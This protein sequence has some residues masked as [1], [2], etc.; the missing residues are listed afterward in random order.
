MIRLYEHEP[1]SDVPSFRLVGKPVKA[2][3][4]RMPFGITFSPGDKRLAVGYYDTAAVD[5]LDGTTLNR[6]SRQSPRDVKV[7]DVGTVSVEWSRDGQTLFAAGNVYDAK[8]RNLL[9]AWDRAGLG[10]ESRMTYCSPGTDTG[11]DALLGGR[12]LV[13]TR[14][15]V[16]ASWTHVANRSGPSRRRYS[17]R[18][19][20]PTSCACLRTVKS[21]ISGIVDPP[22]PFLGLI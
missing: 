10:R 18:G 22:A 3:S 19:I 4:G 12:I 9:F 15:P 14:G 2:P 11:V 5:I 20:K 8:D 13:A 6:V 17:F 21:S 16:S 7:G 1:N